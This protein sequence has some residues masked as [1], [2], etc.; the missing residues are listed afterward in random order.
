LDAGERA[1][2]KTWLRVGAA[3]AVPEGRGLPGSADPATVALDWSTDAGQ[4]WT[5]AA[6]RA[7]GYARAFGL[8][9]DLPPGTAARFLQ[10]RVRWESV[11]DWAPVL[12]GVWADWLRLDLPP[13]RRRWDVTIRVR[14]GQVRRDGGVD[15]RSG[16]AQA[17]ELWAA[18]A[19]GTPVSFRDVDFDADPVV[20]SVRVVAIA[21]EETKPGSAGRWGDGE[22]GLK[23][24][25]A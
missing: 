22:V 10:L 20:R 19:T 7:G 25:E 15:P 5:P 14:D 2:T 9:A 4:S 16:R 3:F 24:V 11:L 8:A 21:Q 23:L 17:A 12:T 1:A 18:W 13:S 6:V